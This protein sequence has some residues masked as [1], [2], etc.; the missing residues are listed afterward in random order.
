MGSEETKLDLDTTRAFKTDVQ[1]SLERESRGKVHTRNNGKR[2]GVPSTP[3]AAAGGADV[4]NLSDTGA[5]FL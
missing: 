1:E 5:C 2:S 4:Y 3:R